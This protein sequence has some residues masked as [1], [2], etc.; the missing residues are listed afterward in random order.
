[1]PNRMPLLSPSSQTN[2][3]FRCLETCAII[4][5]PHRYL[6]GTFFQPDMVLRLFYFVGPRTQLLK[7][8]TS[9][10][11]PSPLWISLFQFDP[12]FG[13]NFSVVQVNVSL[14]GTG[15]V[16]TS[17]PSSAETCPNLR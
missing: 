13:H 11:S 1:M 9:T 5:A 17:D 2:F 15:R 8:S 16:V 4:D 3:F 6:I 14:N 12:L 7:R 10:A